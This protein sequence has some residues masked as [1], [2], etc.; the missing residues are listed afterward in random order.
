VLGANL[1]GLR[2]EPE[3]AGFVTIPRDDHF[4]APVA[5]DHG[6]QGIFHARSMEAARIQKYRAIADRGSPGRTQAPPNRRAASS[7]AVQLSLTQ[8]RLRADRIIASITFCTSQPSRKSA[9][10]CGSP[11]MSS[12]KS[13]ISMVFR[14]LNPS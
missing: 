7:C 4:W 14:S 5:G 13:R 9:R 1:T 11:A 6:A 12:R 3:S 2:N 8:C 10:A